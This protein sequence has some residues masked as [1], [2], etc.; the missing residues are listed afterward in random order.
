MI[1]KTK[2]LK[3]EENTFLVNCKTAQ[4]AVIRIDKHKTEKNVLRLTNQ[5]L[6]KF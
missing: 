2:S 1:S 5:S 4:K 3:I 6:N